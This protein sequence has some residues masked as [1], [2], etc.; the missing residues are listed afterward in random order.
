MSNALIGSRRDAI[1]IAQ[2]FMTEGIFEYESSPFK[3][4][5]EEG[6]DVYYRFL[7]DSMCSLTPHSLTPE[8]LSPSPSP[9]S[10]LPSPVLPPSSSPSSSPSL[11]S[12][13]LPSFV[14]DFERAM[15]SYMNEKGAKR[16]TERGRREA[17]REREGVEKEKREYL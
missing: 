8:M 9:S 6:A 1:R 4:R 2:Y 17:E 7:S 16:G 15:Q 3:T 5:F 10:S 12:Y 14:R 11:P 13:S